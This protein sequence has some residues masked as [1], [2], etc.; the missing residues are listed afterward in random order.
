[1]GSTALVKC[2]DARN[3]THVPPSVPMGPYTV[4]RG[5][6]VVTFTTSTS[7]AQQTVFLI[8]A[9]RVASIDS[10]VTPLLGTYGTGVNVPGT[11]ETTIPDT[12]VTN[13]AGNLQTSTGNGQLHAFTVTVQCTSSATNASGVVYAGALAQRVGRSNYAT[14]NGLGTALTARR[15]L[16]SYS[17][18]TS[19][20]HPIVLSAYPVDMT[21]WSMQHPIISTDANLS[22]NYT[23]DTL[24]QIA[25]VFPNTSTAVEYN[26]TI[27]TEWRVNFTDQILSSTSIRHPPTPP[28]VWHRVIDMAANLSGKVHDVGQVMQN[29]TELGATVNAFRGVGARLGQLGQLSKLI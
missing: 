8:G 4:V 21:E 20:S 26:V 10:A 1:M 3:L 5:R 7:P 2:I 9:H 19:M 18:Y 28:D 22:N 16:Q 14:W 11:T 6:A 23:T 27:V 13:Y 25:L 29:F 17:A 15:E 12:A 24:S